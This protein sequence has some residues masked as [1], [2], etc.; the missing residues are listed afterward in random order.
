MTAYAYTRD[1]HPDREA[2]NREAARPLY[3]EPRCTSIPALRLVPNHAAL[4]PMDVTTA[5]PNRAA[6]VRGMVSLFVKPLV[7]DF[8]HG[9]T[10]YTSDDEFRAAIIEDV[11]EYAD[12]IGLDVEAAEMEARRLLEMLL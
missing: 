12:E 7:H 10:S 9:H 11:R 6:I 5:E 4:E 8:W 3:G 2:A 1:P